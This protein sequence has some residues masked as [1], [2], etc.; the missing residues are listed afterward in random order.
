[1]AENLIGEWKMK[2]LF[3]VLVV[4][5]GVLTVVACD[6]TVSS[7][8]GSGQNDILPVE[9]AYV[10]IMLPSSGISRS[11]SLDNAKQYTNYYLV[12]FKRTDTAEP[13]YF[14]ADASSSAVYIELRVPVGQY[15]ILLFAGN[16]AIVNPDKPLLLASAYK[17][18]QNILLEEIN[19]INLNLNLVEFEINVPSMIV[20]DE[21][22]LLLI[23]ADS[24]FE[25]NI[26][27]NFHN[28]LI[29]YSDK[30]ISYI[31]SSISNNFDI[32]GQLENP[33]YN[34]ST[35]D[36]TY[37]K[38]SF[39]AGPDGTGAAITINAASIKPFG[40]NELNDWNI[41]DTYSNTFVNFFRIV[42]GFKVPETKINIQWPDE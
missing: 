35:G 16:K 21:G 37:N 22:T 3:V 15:D 6:N 4:L 20:A 9:G 17:Q 34:S 8:K 26:R 32:H 30:V 28:P 25:A 2:K 33:I 40:Y 41:Y 23:E 11:I 24:T 7:E 12:T 18:G 36:Y 10:R 13:E 19:V 29:I 31:Y 5:I 1:M 39:V 27:I 14:S 42:F 38:K